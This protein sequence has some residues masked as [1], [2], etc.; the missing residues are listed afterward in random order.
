MQGIINNT[1][2]YHHRIWATTAIGR[3]FVG[4]T[5]LTIFTSFQAFSEVFHL[6]MKSVLRILLDRV[7]SKM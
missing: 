7:L 3:G 6:K 2:G 1:M 4:G 5:C